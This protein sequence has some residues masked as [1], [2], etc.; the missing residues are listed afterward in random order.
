MKSVYLDNNATT[1]LDVRVFEQMQPYFMEH[2]GNPSSIHS[3]GLRAKQ[4]I[5]R[6]R[7]QVAEAIN[8]APN[9]IIFTSGGTE[10]DNLAVIGS[11]YANQHHGKHVITSEIEHPAV[12][13]S[14]EFL[15]KNGFEVTYVGC[16][17]DGVIEVADIDKAIRPDTILISVMHANNEIGTIQPIEKISEIALKNNILFHTDAVQ[18]VGKI[19]VDVQSLGVDMLSLSAHKFHGP[20]GVGALYIREG[21][22]VDPVL[23]GGGQEKGLSSGTQ[24]VPA[25]VGLGHACTLIP[26]FINSFEMNIAKRKQFE[27]E[28]IS[29]H[30]CILIGANAKRIPST[31]T[32]AFKRRLASELVREYD[33]KGM[34][35]SD[36]SACSSGT[37][38]ISHV[39]KALNLGGKYR[40]GVVRFSGENLSK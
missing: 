5:E 6:A 19:A 7:E 2:F 13:R 34:S 36:G 40:Q 21:T 9:E 17:S 27:D 29:E 25:I 35:V 18:G 20:K 31:S 4:A 33:S 28:M 24:N 26:D 15:E 14:A 3:H 8:A 1:P 38:G 10:S 39:V 11:A 32:F 16:N 23:H 30:D 22:K 12:L 37:I